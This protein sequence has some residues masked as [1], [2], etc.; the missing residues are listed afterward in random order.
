[1]T[2]LLA[3]NLSKML[4]LIMGQQVPTYVAVPDCHGL[5]E[6]DIKN[7]YKSVNVLPGVR[8]GEEIIEVRT[9]GR[10]VSFRMLNGLC[11][12]GYAFDDKEDF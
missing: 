9:P 10:T 4:A 6:M 3:V 12:A 11:L 7:K 2:D 1:M 5:S 8:P